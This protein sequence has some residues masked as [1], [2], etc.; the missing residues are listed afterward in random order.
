[1]NKFVNFV[2]KYVKKMIV[3][4]CKILYKFLYKFIKV[5]DDLCVFISF[6]GRGYSDNPKYIFLE[7]QNDERFKNKKFIWMIKHRNKC[8]VENAKVVTYNSPLYFYYLARAKYWIFNCKMPAYLL[9]KEE[10]VYIQTWHGTPLKRLGHDIVEV[11]NQTFYRSEITR[12][13]MLASYDNDSIK[14]NYMIAPNEFSFDT[15]QSAFNVS[16]DKLIKT[17]YPR[18]DYLISNNNEEYILKLKQKLNIPLNKKVILYAPTWRDNSYSAKGYTFELKVDFNKW[19]E[20]L[21]DDYIVLFK[22]HYLIVNKFEAD[23]KFVYSF[24]ANIDIVD[25]YLVSDVL[26]TDYSSVFFDYANLNKPI[27]FYMFDLSE[28]QDELRGFY[29]DINKDLPGKIFE[30]EL[31][32]VN[33]IKSNDFDYT[34]LLEFNKRFNTY[35][36]GIASKRVLDILYNEFE[37]DSLA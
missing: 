25:L 10:Q 6:H 34:K 14:Y 8:T 17:G 1:M 26:V 31:N 5:D 27:Y 32:L 23:N 29:L 30:D 37:N 33:A 11:E 24:D 3:K 4:A 9:K 19:K 28:Y 2:L 15:F 35:E 20:I 21:G 36:K 18:N 12:E 7:M 13:Q 16:A 22:P